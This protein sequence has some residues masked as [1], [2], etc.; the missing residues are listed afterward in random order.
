MTVHRLSSGDHTSHRGRAVTD[1]T[2]ERTTGD[3]VDEL[4]AWLEEN[5]DPDLT[6][7]EWWERLGW[8]A[9]RRRRCRPTPTA[10]ASPRRRRPGAERD[11][12]PR[13]RSARPA[14]SACC[15]PR[16]R[17][18]PTAPTEQIDRYVR[19]IVT[20]A[21]GVVPAVQRAGRRVRPRRPQPH[22]RARTATSG[23]STA[24]RCG[25]PV[26]Q[27]ADMGMLIA[28]TNPDGAQA[29]GHHLV[30]HRHAPAGRRG[31]PAARR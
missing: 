18:P 17:S 13:R 23:S 19:D 6:V 20:G 8:P 30:R 26:G 4:R 21:E 27:V 9:G 15:S 29:P 31:P 3:V 24:R 1:T 14:G 11:R 5:W 22:G 2:M 7:A 28:R 10:G 12:R 16:R 25:R